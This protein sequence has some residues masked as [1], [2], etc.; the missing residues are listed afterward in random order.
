VIVV[1]DLGIIVQ[2]AAILL[3]L[4]S[5][6]SV[7]DNN[8]SVYPTPNDNSTISSKGPY[9]FVRHPM[10]TSLLVFFIPMV[11][12]ATDW[13]SWTIYGIL[14]ITL[15][16]KIVYEEKLLVKKHPDYQDYKNLT[17]KRLLPYIY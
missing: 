7:G 4:W 5:I 14:T 2:V 9:L 13:F 17:K 6:K 16:C 8:W 15:V 10:Y 3:A 11:I 12:R 1:F